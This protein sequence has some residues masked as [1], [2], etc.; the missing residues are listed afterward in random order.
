MAFLIRDAQAQSYD[1]LWDYYSPVARAKGFAEVIQDMFCFHM[2]AV[3][4]DAEATPIYRC[5]Q[6][7]VDKE[8]GTGEAIQAGDEVYATL[9][10]N[11]QSVSANP[12]GVI[13][14]NYYY[15]GVAKKNAGANEATVLIKF[16][17]DEYNQADRAAV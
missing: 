15:C 3:A 7:R 16:M 11:F 1:E 13:G 17:G 10:S 4:A 12:A 8:I 6:V 14:V 9:G 5:T 2:R